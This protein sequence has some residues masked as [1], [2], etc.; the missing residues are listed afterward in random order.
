VADRLISPFGWSAFGRSF[1]G[2]MAQLDR[3]KGNLTASFF[4]PTQG[5]WENN[6]STTMDN[7]DIT[8]LTLTAKRGSF[9]PGMEIAGF[10]YKYRDDRDVTQRVDNTPLSLAPAPDGVDIDISMIGG[11]ALGVYDLGPGKLD[12]LLWGGKQFGDWYELDHDAYA[13]SAEM[14]YQFVDVFAKPWFRAGYYIGSGDGDPGDGDHETFFQM[15]PGTRKYNLLPYCDLMNIEDTF[16]QMI[17]YPI[18]NMTLRADYH[19]LSLNNDDDRWY[20]GSGPTQNDGGIFGYIGRPSHGDSQLAQELDFIM[21]YKLNPHWSV[22]GSY[23]HIFGG[24]IVDG[25]YTK[26]NDAD[27][28]SVELQLVF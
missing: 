18:K 22:A 16:V 19:V 23:S 21:Q 28:F 6:I 15:A 3:P 4:Y 25:V 11:H 7:I 27:Y 17:T 26:D 12:L 10:Y 5:G 1:D 8:T 20:M 13:V 9:I 2:V 24:D 14:G